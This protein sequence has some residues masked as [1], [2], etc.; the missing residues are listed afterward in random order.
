[1]TLYNTSHALLSSTPLQ[2]MCDDVT[3][4]E[5]RSDLEPRAE[6]HGPLRYGSKCQIE[7]S[8]AE[9][10]GLERCGIPSMED[11]GA[12]RGRELLSE[13]P[14]EDARS[15]TQRC[16]AS[17]DEETEAE[18]ARITSYISG[19]RGRGIL[20]FSGQGGQD[21]EETDP[22]IRAIRTDY[23][24]FVTRW[25]QERE[26]IRRIGELLRQEESE[27]LGFETDTPDSSLDCDEG[28]S[29]TTDEDSDDDED[30]APPLKRARK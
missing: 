14:Q 10:P 29:T 27:V 18:E 11:Q 17:T 15:K 30:Y 21:L 24:D 13:P 5:F 26:R 1:M 22:L 4:P 25:A 3:I 2:H 16:G 7:N 6:I 8:G 12:R 9:L 28:L 23:A 20:S 19:A